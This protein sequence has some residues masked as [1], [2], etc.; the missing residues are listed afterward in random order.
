MSAPTLPPSSPASSNRWDWTS[1][2]YRIAKRMSLGTVTGW[3]ILA[4][5]TFGGCSALHLPRESYAFF[6]LLGI[7]TAVSQ[8]VWP[9]RPRTAALV[10][11][12]A[13][14]AVWIEGAALLW[15][16][17][18]GLLDHSVSDLVG[19][20]VSGAIFGY[21]FGTLTT[22]VLLVESAIRSLV[23]RPHSSALAS[24]SPTD[25]SDTLAPNAVSLLAHQR[26][27]A[28]GVPRAPSG[29]S[30]PPPQTT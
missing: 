28:Q 29:H 18:F 27:S 11:G 23:Q 19:I 6:L 7:S 10:A 13:V 3:V 17:R 16:H 21:I 12:A 1:R 5:L 9:S 26:R 20:V 25:A 2:E 4:A 22:S 30:P 14:M 24:E 8:L 15:P